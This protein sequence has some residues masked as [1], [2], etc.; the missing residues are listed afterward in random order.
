VFFYAGFFR[1]QEEERLGQQPN[2]AGKPIPS[3]WLQIERSIRW[4][5]WAPSSIANATSAPGLAADLERYGG[6]E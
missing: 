4:P 3:R 5:V 1:L 6:N 2:S